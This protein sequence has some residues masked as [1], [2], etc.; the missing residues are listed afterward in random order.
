MQTKK[1]QVG[2]ALPI[3]TTQ[4]LNF[5][6]CSGEGLPIFEPEDRRFLVLP[7]KNNMLGNTKELTTN[8]IVALRAL[9]RMNGSL[10]VSEWIA[11]T[12]WY[13]RLGSFEARLIE[14]V[15]MGLIV[16]DGPRCVM[17]ERGYVQIDGKPDAFKKRGRK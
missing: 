17:T 5:V 13:R 6:F 11:K 12:W 16:K 14:W 3:R 7:I 1:L 15:K 8:D 9:A 2:E 10:L 4:G